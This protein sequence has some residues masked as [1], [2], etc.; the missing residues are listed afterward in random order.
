MISM[1]YLNKLLKVIFDHPEAYEELTNLL[2][3][4]QDGANRCD[5]L[6]GS[7]NKSYSK[8]VS[9]QEEMY[10]S[11]SSPMGFDAEDMGHE[12]D[13]EDDG[14]EENLEDDEEHLEDDEEHLEDDEEHLE[15]DGE[16]ASRS[17]NEERKLKKKFAHHHILD[18]MKKHMM[19]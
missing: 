15:D 4:E 13:L 1:G 10:E 19:N 9:D 17:G 16:I 8:F 14:D 11:V 12:D 5:S 7:M 6:V 2:N 3:D 18:A